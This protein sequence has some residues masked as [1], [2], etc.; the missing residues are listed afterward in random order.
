MLLTNFVFIISISFDCLAFLDSSSLSSHFWP[1]NSCT[2]GN[3]AR[4]YTESFE[5]LKTP[6]ISYREGNGCHGLE[7][8]GRRLGCFVIDAGGRTCHRRWFTFVRGRRRS[9]RSTEPRAAG[10]HHIQSCSSSQSF[11]KAGSPRKGS[12]IGSNLRRAG[13]MGVRQAPVE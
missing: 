11:W 9:L 7:L 12:Q 1:F 5:V 10:H 8:Y 4:G 6:R 2:A 13:V 3:P